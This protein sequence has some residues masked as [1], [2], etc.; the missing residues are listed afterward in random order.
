MTPTLDQLWRWQDA[1]GVTL[2]TDNEMFALRDGWY[3]KPKPRTCAAPRPKLIF[4]LD[5]PN[6]LRQP[7]LDKGL[8]DT[9]DCLTEKACVIAGHYERYLPF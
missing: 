8:V 2:I 3:Q 4:G 6:A 9:D 1:D 7:M 5:C